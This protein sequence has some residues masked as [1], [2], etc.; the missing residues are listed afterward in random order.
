M[1]VKRI[2]G[3]YAKSLLDLAVE[4]GNLEEV[5]G[6][7]SSFTEIVKSRDFYL[8]VKSPIVSTAKKLSIFKESFDGKYGTLTNAFFDIILRKGRESY[9]PEITEEFLELYNDHKGITAV[10]I[11]TAAPLSEEALAGIKAQLL[12]SDITASELEVLTIVEPDLI[13]GFVLMI[14]DNLYDASVAHKLETLRKTFKDNSYV[15][16]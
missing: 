11:R 2:A 6:D 4:Q 12:A 7:I 5:K 15:T 3:R 1:S 9:L 14:G 8:L 10:T 13:G 16:A